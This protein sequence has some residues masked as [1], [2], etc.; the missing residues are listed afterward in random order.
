M[1]QRVVNYT[2]GTGNPVLPDGSID[3]RDGIDNLQSFDIFINAEEDTYNQRDGEIVQ[4][5]AGAI[6]STGFKPG[7]G[8]FTTGFTVM[9]GERG[10][11]WYDPVS[12]N[13]YSYLGVIPSGGYVVPPLT[14]PVGSVDWKPVTDNLL[15]ADL[16]STGGTDLIGYKG[17]MSLTDLIDTEPA[18]VTPYIT[19]A[20]THRAGFQAAID[21]GSVRVPAGSNITISGDI[22]I[23]ANR[24]IVVD[25]G[26]TITS[27][28]RFTAY[29]VNNVHWIINGSVLSADMAAAP[30]KS[31]WPNTAQGTQ[32]GNERGFIEFGGVT[33]AG[34]DGSNYSVSIGTTGVVAGDWVGTPNF[35][36][37]VRQV[38]RKGIAA[39]NCSNVHFESDGEIYGFEGEAVYWFS[40]SAAS[41][42]VY[43]RVNNLHDCRFNG[44]NVNALLDVYNVKIEKCVTRN[45]YQGIESSAGDVLDCRDY[46]S[47]QHSI[48]A[49]QGHG[50]GKRMITGNQSFNCLGV[51]FSI[52]YDRNYESLGR[53]NTV[54]ITD[55]HATDPANG[56]LAIADIDNIQAH[57]NTCKGMQEGRFLQVA[58]CQG[59]ALTGNI[60]FNPSAGTEHYYEAD[61]HSLFKAGN[62]KVSLGGSYNALMKAN[63]DFTGGLNSTITTHGNRENFVDVRATNPNIATGPEYRFSYD[64]TLPFVAATIGAN[65]TGYDASG[66]KADVAINNLKIGT[67]DTLGPSWIFRSAGHFEPSIDGFSNVGS[68]A[69][70]ANT[71]YAATG[72]INTSDEREKIRLE[73]VDAERNAAIE[74][75]QNMWKF[76]FKASNS[77]KNGNGRFHFGVGAQTVGEIMKKHGLDPSRYSFFCYDEWD[78]ELV[79]AV[80]AATKLP[81]GESVTITKAGNRYGIRYDELLCF[82]ISAM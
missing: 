43:M 7:D 58:G 18:V 28:G 56:F 75:K 64:Q 67:G 3:V 82:I 24:L 9:P 78:E 34:N 35:T 40:R 72:T 69:K 61:C 10:I 32:L 22:T 20:A 38:N 81:T 77:E 47:V 27:N 31:G 15:R 17:G 62:K 23:P 21:A 6:R 52:L 60:N 73:I 8:D 71:I 11:S 49:G 30:A 14:N 25:F 46:S 36:D 80:D 44:V 12:L 29:G 70:R 50:G 79:Y 39:W 65:L 4:T 68:P 19:A 1:T 76:Q 54:V 66:A 53:V 42:N 48:Y 37:Q 51:P 74:I 26:A 63:D 5:V 16:T 59:G 45:T 33:F 57:G 41:K 55:N 13:W 2:Y